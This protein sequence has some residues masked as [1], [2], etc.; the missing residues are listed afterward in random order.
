MLKRRSHLALSTI[1]TFSWKGGLTYAFCE[2]GVDG[3][4]TQH[5]AL[6]STKLTRQWL[7]SDSATQ[8]SIAEQRKHI[9][10]ALYR[11]QRVNHMPQD[12]SDSLIPFRVNNVL[13][14][15]VR[16]AIANL[17]T[18]TLDQGNHVFQLEDDSDQQFLTL[19]DSCGSTCAERTAAVAVVTEELR[20]R[21]VI[22]GWRDELYPVASS[23]YDEPVFLMERAAVSFLGILEYGVH[24]NGLVRKQGAMENVDVKMWMA[25]RSATK[26]KYP[27]MLDHIVAGGQ[28]AGISL[29]DNVIKECLEEAGIPESLATAGVSSAGA[30][31]YETYSERSDTISRNILFCFDLHLP[32]SFQ[33][34]PVDGE[35]QEFF[36]WSLKDVLESL[37]EDYADPIKPNC[38]VVIIDWLVRCGH[39][40]PD[41]PGYLDVLRGLR[42]GDCQ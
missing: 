21:G 17:F 14:G 8:F 15:K 23:F 33:P 28:P 34:T 5:R 31:S 19:N 42:S 10:D 4:I 35:V 7:S 29:M 16:P 41:V 32:E 40:S 30:I 25:R 36:L 1:L 6:F 27:G 9:Q 12:V 37:D 18:S 11:I 22:H 24:I 38:Y 39:L 26:S 13:L 20:N 3:S 2:R